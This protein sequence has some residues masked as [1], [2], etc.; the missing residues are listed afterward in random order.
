MSFPASY[1]LQE[2][3]LTK[4]DDELHDLKAGNP[5]LPPDL[6]TP[7]AL[8]VVP[9]HDYM[10]SQVEGDDDPRDGGRADKLGIAE[11]SGRAMVVAVKEGCETLY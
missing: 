9:V 7:S 6:D 2:F 5:L 1:R 10:D 11:E 8:E 3:E 4:I